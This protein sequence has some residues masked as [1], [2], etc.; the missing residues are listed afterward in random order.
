TVVHGNATAG[1]AYQPGLSDY[2][3]V[4]RDRAKM[5]LAGPPLL[6]AATGEI[7]TDEDLGGAEMHTGVAGTAE[8]LA[9][10]DAD[11]IRQARDLMGVL[12]VR[13]D[14][15]ATDEWA[16]PRY[17]EEELLGVV[18]SDAKK[19]YDVREVI[20]RIADDSNFVDFKNDWDAA[21]VCGW[22]AIEGQPVGVLG[23]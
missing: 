2:V 7:A 8:Y 21:T 6:K 19:P 20:A 12:G 5:F 22:I 1:G 17:D 3:I 14:A 15:L 10:D 18:P 4:V 11:G 13:D 23:N 16:P 9:D